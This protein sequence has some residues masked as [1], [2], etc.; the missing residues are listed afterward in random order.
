MIDTEGKNDK[1]TNT[2]TN[3]ETKTIQGE[4]ILHRVK[5]LLQLKDSPSHETFLGQRIW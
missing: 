5:K 1:Q 4:I 2:Y 3:K